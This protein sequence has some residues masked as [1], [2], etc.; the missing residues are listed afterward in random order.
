MV[1]YKYKQSVFFH[2]FRILRIYAV[3]V[4]GGLNLK[5]IK[6]QQMKQDLTKYLNN[7]DNTGVIILGVVFLLVVMY[8]IVTESKHDELI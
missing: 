2:G 4:L 6:K 5:T 3:S 8:W 1:G 7:T